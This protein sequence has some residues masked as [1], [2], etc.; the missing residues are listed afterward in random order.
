[1]DRKQEVL[2]ILPETLRMILNRKT[3]EFQWL[4][5]I[6]L[7]ICEPFLI[8][9]HNQEW[10]LTDT[11]ELITDTQKAYRITQR[12]IK[13]TLERMSHYSLYA[14]EEEIKQGFLTIQGGHRVG[15]AGKVVM[16]KGLLRGM[17]YITFLNIRVSHE[18]VG[19]GRRVIPFIAKENQICHTLIISP[20]GCGKTTLLRD[21]IRMISDGEF[22]EDA[23]VQTRLVEQRGS[24]GWSVGVVDERSELGACYQGVPQNNLGGKT[25]ILDCCPKAFG[26]MMLIRSMAPKVIAV[27]EIGNREDVDAITYAMNSGCKI[28]A[29]IHGTSMEEVRNKPAIRKLVE[30]RLFE[31]YILLSKEKGIGHVEHIFDAQGNC[32]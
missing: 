10:F 23:T 8:V 7:R 18:I 24:M 6:R 16:E 26:M 30:E 19:C 9:Y 25:D 13:E 31:R 12:D 20:P 22:G 27:D 3:I 1:M 32:L 2:S 21:L 5:E 17:S 15:L 28:L 11:G 4:Q 14:F 29:T